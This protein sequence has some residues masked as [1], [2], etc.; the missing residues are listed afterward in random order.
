MPAAFQRLKGGRVAGAG[1][2]KMSGI[3]AGQRVGVRKEM[4]EIARR[5]DIMKGTRE[6]VVRPSCVTAFQVEA[7]AVI[8]LRGLHTAQR[9]PARRRTVQGRHEQMND[10]C[11]APGSAT[12]LK[13]MFG[14]ATKAVSIEEMN[15]SIAA[16]GAEAGSLVRDVKAVSVIPRDEVGESK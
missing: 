2:Q 9:P 4:G 5:R 6:V 8:V 1:V 15:R 11:I 12:E 7:G 13:G 14:R 10:E 16:R 3:R